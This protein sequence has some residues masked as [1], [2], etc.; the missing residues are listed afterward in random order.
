MIFFWSEWGDTLPLARMV[1]ANGGASILY[2]DEDEG[3]HIGEGLVD[4]S[5]NPNPPR[6][7]IVILDCTGKGDVGSDYRNRGFA[8]VGGNPYDKL[9]GKSRRDG[10]R[11][12]K[13][14]G[15][16]TPEDH[17]FPTIAK[18]VSFLE[19]QDGEWFVKV[20]GDLGNSSTANGSSE[21]LSR[22]L[23][24]FSGSNAKVH[25]VELQKKAE[26]A[27]IS[28]EGW[29]DGQRFVFPFNATIEEKKLMAGDKGPRTGCES[30]VIFPYDGPLCAEL[31]K[32]EDTLRDEDYV[33][34]LDL[35]MIV[36]EKGPLGLEWTARLGFDASDAL[37]RLLG[38][39]LPGQLEAFAYGAL[40]AWEFLPAMALTLRFSVPP[41]PDEHSPDAKKLLGYPLD[42]KVLNLDVTDVRMGSDGPECA[43]RDG[44]LGVATVVGNDISKLRSECLAQVGAL[45]ISNLQYRIDPVTR[46]EKTMG[47]LSKKGLV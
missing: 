11:I 32:L 2:T 39:T 42:K 40:P 18:A 19:D 24:W 17:Y 30:C 8:V 15:I 20:D 23:H 27:E 16:A 38:P 34:S 45:K 28:I 22:Y 14:H 46:W 4:V 13:E 44:L 3:E 31:L 1:D 25:G 10:I 41:Y 26:G 12:M 9:L 33:G 47:A 6:G 35:N 37:F 36:T 7:S 21:Y 43:G 29:F 5:S